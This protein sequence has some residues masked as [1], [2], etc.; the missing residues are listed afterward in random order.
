[1]QCPWHRTHAGRVG[2]SPP[3][4]D[5]APVTVSPRP[6]SSSR[7]RMPPLMCAAARFPA[8]RRG[9]WHSV[10]VAGL[11]GCPLLG[12]AARPGID[13]T[14]WRRS[15]P[16]RA[17]LAR[18]PMPG[19]AAPDSDSEAHDP[20]GSR[21]GG[22]LACQATGRLLAHCVAVTSFSCRHRVRLGHRALASSPRRC[23]SA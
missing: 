2:P 17:A 1:L 6:P 14:P 7:G 8:A 10:P 5:S 3:E 15:H 23:R 11:P 16:Q 13:G 18:F 12:S 20:A 9:H 22:A 21:G 4:L 19:A